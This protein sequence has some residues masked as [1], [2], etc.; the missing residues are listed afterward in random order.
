MEGRIEKVTDRGIT[1]SG[2]GHGRNRIGAGG[3]AGRGNL[4]LPLPAAGNSGGN[5]KRMMRRGWDQEVSDLYFHLRR[6]APYSD[7]TVNQWSIKFDR[8]EGIASARGADQMTARDLQDAL[9]E[10]CDKAE[11][12][13]A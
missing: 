6:Q 8:A 3:L 12:A 2:F 11:G 5:H 7:W 4:S 10:C 13:S 9:R 1:R